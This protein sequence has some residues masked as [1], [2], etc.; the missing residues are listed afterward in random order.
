MSLI[1]LAGCADK[2]K[3]ANR[4]EWEDLT[5][6]DI[7][8]E[9]DFPDEGAVVLYDE[10]KMEIFS[11]GPTGFSEFERHKIIKILNVRGEKYA[12]VMIPFFP[13][14]TIDDIQARTIMPSGKISVLEEKDIYD[15][16][17]YPNFVFYSDQRAK[18]FTMPAIAPG[19]VIEYR[20]KVSIRDRTLWHSWTFQDKIPTLLSRYTLIHP[21]QWNLNYKLY[22]LDIEP[23]EEIAPVGFKA[24]RAWEARNL[25]GLKSEFGMPSRKNSVARLTFAPNGVKSWND[26][27]VWYDNLASPQ[28]ES[29]Y[30]MKKLAK[31][32]T[33]GLS[34]DEEKLRAIFEWVRDN[35]RYIAVEI[36]MGGYEPYP[37]SE[38]F[39]NRYGDCKDM[40]TLLCGLADASNIQVDE[41]LISTWQNGVIDTTL[42]SPFQFN[43]AIAYCPTVGENGIWMDATDKGCAFGSLPWYDQGL[44]ALVVG[45]RGE[46]SLKITSR[47]TDTSNYS[48]MNWEV[49]LNSDGFA[50]VQARTLFS[51]VMASEMRA[52][53]YYLSQEEIRQWLDMHIAKR[54]IGTTLDSFRVDALREIKDPLEISFN[55]QSKGFARKRSKQLILQPGTFSLF[56]LPKW[57]RSQTR[58]YPIQ[59]RFPFRQELKMVIQIPDS[60]QTAV[61]TFQDSLHTEFGSATWNYSTS[62]NILQLHVTY[63][64]SKSHIAQESYQDFLN[65]LHELQ[66]KDQWEIML[67]SQNA[68]RE[69]E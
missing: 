40:T 32:L 35:V 68:E 20:Y 60:Y 23:R 67:L 37:A 17:L 56:E 53:L 28:T 18:I 47:D 57:F 66:L 5:L 22:N 42:P 25:P 62:Q 10:G 4:I 21:A 44:P 30:E 39:S 31:E 49:K 14:V 59:F 19:S 36:G 12:N 54:C 43:H 1:Y 61:S 38:V 8:D 15:V 50:L 9:Q 33:H 13:G 34:G 7:P 58:S 41:V 51:G 45:K 29:N 16:N 2:N 63:T 48:Y 55:F 69:T 46:A 11:S 52:D 65:F 64:L 26:V 27:A 3:W 24:T 6:S